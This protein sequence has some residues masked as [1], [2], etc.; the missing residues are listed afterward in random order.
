MTGNKNT[1]FRDLGEDE[2]YVAALDGSN[3]IEGGV[4]AEAVS[5]IRAKKKFEALQRAKRQEKKGAF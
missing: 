5:F 1:M 3:D 2:T 4:D